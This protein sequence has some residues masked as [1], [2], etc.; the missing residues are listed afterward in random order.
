MLSFFSS[1]GRSSLVLNEDQLSSLV[2]DLLK[3]LPTEIFYKILKESLYQDKLP[4]IS[5][6]ILNFSF[7]EKWNPDNT[8]NIKFVEP[9]IFVRFDNFDII[10]EAKR[11]NENQQYKDQL[12]NQIQS[13]FNEF[14]VD[15]KELIYVQVGGLYSKTNEDN[16]GDKEIK[17]CK[18]DWSKILNSI[19]KMKD[20]LEIL[21][22][23]SSQSSIRI[24]NDLIKGFSLFNFNKILWLESLES[25][26][27]INTNINL[28]TRNGK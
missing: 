12:V 19:V 2:F 23:D 7:W 20:N 4:K 5:G 28:F 22:L 15:N 26:N 13:Y 27:K 17:I 14:S 16:F 3:Y 18:T 8:T 25:K 10:L 24:L 9:D 21:N 11:Y 1:K 6:N